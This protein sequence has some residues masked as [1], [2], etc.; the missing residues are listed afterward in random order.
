MPVSNRTRLYREFLTPTLHRRFTQAA[1]VSLVIC[2]VEAVILGD[3]SSLLWS[4]FPLGKAGIRTLLLFLSALLVFVLR[5]AQLHCGDRSTASSF[6]TFKQYLH[7]RDILETSFCYVFSAL[8][9]SEIYIWSV[10]KEANLNWVVHGRPWERQRLNE[11]PVYL[12]SLYLG[13]ALL[14]TVLHLT[15]D[16]DKIRGSVED[17]SAK[18]TNPVEQLRSPLPGILREIG[19]ISLGS[20]LLGPIIY[21][22]TIRRIAWRASLAC[23][24]FLRWDIPRTAELSYIPPYHITLIFRSLT[25]SFCLLLLWR[26]AN[27]AFSVYTA[28]EPLKRGQPLIHESNDPNGS[29]INGLKSRKQIVKPKSAKPSPNAASPS[30][31]TSTAQPAPPGPKSLPNASR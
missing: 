29:L 18:T 15:F 11:R 24:R 31:K 21:S 12:R 27:L 10:P 17:A 14:Q 6:Q 22:L 4:W 25:S 19:F 5:V 13:L 7:R 23:A 9:F 26:S 28:Q 30:F 2:Y 8:L 3:K 20:S 1:G 16:Y